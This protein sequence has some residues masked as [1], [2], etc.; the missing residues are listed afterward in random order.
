MDTNLY[1]SSGKYPIDSVDLRQL[2]WTDPL[3]Y[4]Y[5]H[6]F[7]QLEAFYIGSPITP[8]TLN[9]VIKTRQSWKTETTH[10]GDIVTKQLQSRSAPPQALKAAEQLKEKGTVAVLTGQQAG[11]FGGPL[12]T[13]FKSLTAIALA[14]QIE[15]EHNIS[16]VPIF[17]I[18]AEDHDLDEICTCN[19][20]DSDSNLH[21]VDLEL[22]QTH[23]GRPAE[24]VLLPDSITQTIEALDKI[25][26]NTEFSKEILGQLIRTYSPGI[27]LVEAFSRWLDII[28]GPM[29]LVVFDGSDKTAKPLV[30]SVFTQELQSRGKVSRLATLAGKEF[31]AH[32]YHSQ[33][34]PR[35]DTAAIFH[36]DKTRL[37][38]KLRDNEFEIGN[39]IWTTKQ[40]LDEVQR[41]PNSFSPNVL[42]RPLVQDTLFPTIVYVAGPSEVAYLGQL[43]QVYAEFKIPMPLIYPRLSATITDGAT[44]K[45]LKRYK[46][47]FET[48][49][50]Q[51]DSTLNQLLAN[52]L[53]S[54]LDSIIKDTE[55]RVYDSLQKI[56]DEVPSV[57]PTLAETV[58]TTQKQM[59]RSLQ[60]LH[61]KII[62]AAKR[63]NET[64]QRQ[65]YR[66]QSLTFPK[67]KAQERNIAFLYFLNM[68]GPKLVDKLLVNL[69]LKIGKH[70]LLNP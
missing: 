54:D 14:R 22:P 5:C 24:S 18:D 17:W 40:L 12:F 19:L 49:Q 41:S 30:R 20:L 62:K 63:K 1:N 51:D 27:S 25:L 45:F 21:R 56:K 26:P 47:N 42:L 9:H 29:G 8:E 69:P 32:G 48:L 38:V 70:Y 3:T 7:K 67:G 66:A 37:P 2:T 44:M 46:I 28:L 39:T 11:L 33:V 60:T 64:L 31:S 55:Q 61:G 16:A 43:K 53:P 50:G 4:D 6:N 13:L 23:S 34:N 15:K 36:I 52:H 65:F 58:K 10:I 59:E 35:R 68:Y 57:D